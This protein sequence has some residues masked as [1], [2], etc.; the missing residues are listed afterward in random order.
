[1]SKAR[2]PSYRFHKGSGQAMVRLNGKSFNLGAWQSPESKAEYDR[3]IA[4][5][6]VA[7]RAPEQVS[8]EAGPTIAG[9]MKRYWAFA[10]QY[11]RDHQTG[12]PAREL[13]NV[14]HAIRPVGRLYGAEPAAK[15]GPVAF[16]AVRR[17]MVEAGL[18][19][20]TINSR[21]GKIR[22]MFKWAIAAELIPPS[23]LQGIKAVEPLR[24]HQDGV[25]ERAKVKPVAAEAVAAALPFCSGPIRAMIELQLLTGMRPGE[26][27]ALRPGDLDRAGDVWIYRPGRHK[28]QSRGKTRSIAIGPRAQA[29]LLPWLDRDPGA[30]CFSPAEAVATRNATARANRRSKMTPSQAARRPK[31]DPK[32]APRDHY[33][34]WTYATAIERACNRA[35]PHPVLGKSKPEE[36]TADQAAEIAAWQKEHRWHP[37]QLRHSA[38]T[39]VRKRFGLEAAQTVLG[40]SKA[41]V[42][43]IYAE[44]D[45]AKAI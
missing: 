2:I 43:Q 7:S 8:A 35:F 34:R 28:T 14:R 38:A 23:V 37:N 25:R 40:H 5:W 19:R 45:L 4:E 20:G 29:I 44:R 41:D 11:Y 13:E 32:K 6:L 39:E 3:L 24:P 16:R 22:R 33:G 26:V 12:E 30:F 36:L 15:F 1:M 17:S 42:T 31:A 9:L 10:E 21:L 18:S 27:M